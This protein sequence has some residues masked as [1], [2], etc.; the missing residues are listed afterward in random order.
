MPSTA[1]TLQ[2]GYVYF[3]IAETPTYYD[4]FAIGGDNQNYGTFFHD[5]G[6]RMFVNP[7]STGTYNRTISLYNDNNERIMDMTDTAQQ[8]WGAEV[9]LHKNTYEV[10][11]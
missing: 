10:S 11:L 4:I 2:N 6:F 5:S 9:A 3:F 8:P 7:T 1:L